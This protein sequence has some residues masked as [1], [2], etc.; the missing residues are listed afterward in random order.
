MD[1]V[2]ANIQ[3]V[4]F[5]GGGAPLFD[6]QGKITFWQQRVGYILEKAKAINDSGVYFPV[7][8]T[9]FGM[10][11]MT[12]AFLGNTSEKLLTCNY[13]DQDT[14]H[15]VS[16]N[17]NFSKSKIW[18]DLDKDLVNKAFSSG[19]LYYSH[20]CGFDPVALQ[21]DP[22]FAKEAMVTATSISKNGMKFVA[23][24]EHLKYPFFANQWHPEK[25]QFERIGPT[26]L[27]RDATTTKFTSEF[28]M[29]IVDKTRKFSKNLSQVDGATRAFF[30][31]YHIPERPA[32]EDFEQ[33][34]TFQ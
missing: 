23:M 27:S 31:V 8:G 7:V 14:N 24:V 5:I 6:Q 26:W 15:S 25:T 18:G 13:N 1:H 10:Q 16:P 33:I 29:T 30:E 12:V 17:A 4:H 3:G 22:V 9:C 2:L 28:I 34:Y 20:N 32:W 11:S 21:N 19:Y